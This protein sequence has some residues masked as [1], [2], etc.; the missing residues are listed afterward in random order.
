MDGRDDLPAPTGGGID[1]RPSGEPV[2]R[3]DEEKEVEEPDFT[4]EGLDRSNDYWDEI[5]RREGLD[6]KPS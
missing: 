2:R 6:K 5:G 4:D 1:D 3:P